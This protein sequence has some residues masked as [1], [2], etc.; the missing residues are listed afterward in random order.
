[1]VAPSCQ[2]WFLELVITTIKKY[3]FGFEVIKSLV[4]DKPFEFDLEKFKKDNF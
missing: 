4:D 1:L 2:D 3:G